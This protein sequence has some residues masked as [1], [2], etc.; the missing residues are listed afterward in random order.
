M[1]LK[2]ILDERAFMP[3]KAHDDDAGYDIRALK[4]YI[5][6]PHKKR[7]VET[8][9][10]IQ[11]QKDTVAYVKNRSSMFSDGIIT[12]GTIDPGYTGPIKVVLFNTNDEHRLVKRGDKVAQLVLHPILSPQFEIVNKFEE[13][14][15]GDGGFGSSG[16]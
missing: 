14:D 2:V 1:K 6:R 10:H 15:R 13:T 5:L 4:G 7:V 16:R 12:D 11:L 8:G 9:V 3:E